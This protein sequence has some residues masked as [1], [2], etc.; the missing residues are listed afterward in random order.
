VSIDLRGRQLQGGKYVLQETIAQGGMATVYTA[1]MRSLDA[2]V[3][4]KILD[5]RFAESEPFRERFRA[6]AH[7]LAALHHPNIIEV[8]DLD[9]DNSVM[10]I[11]MRYVGNGTLKDYLRQIGGPID[12]NL[13]AKL[14]AQIASALQCAHDAGVVHQDIKPAN[15]LL[16]SADWPLLS[17]FGIAGWTVGEIVGT[18][19]YMS[20]EQWTGVPLDGRADQYALALVF[21]QLVAGRLPFQT[22]TISELKTQHLTELP[23]S[24]R[25]FNPGVPGPVDEVL[26]RALSKPREHRFPRIDDFATALVESV[27]RSRGMQLETKQAIVDAT[28]N[29]L[30]AIGVALVTPQLVALANPNL[31]IIGT[32]TLNWPILL[33]LALIESALLL[34]IRW[35]LVGLLARVFSATIDA[36]DRITRM[37][38]RLGTDAEGPLR[39]QRWRNSIVGSAEGIVGIAYVFALY[40]IVGPPLIQTI[41][42]G[43]DYRLEPLIATVVAALVLILAGANVLAI[44]RTSGSVLGT[45]A[46]ALCWAFIAGMPTADRAGWGGISLQWSAKLVIGM[47]VV[48]ALFRVRKDVQNAFRQVV[49]SFFDSSLGR[50]SATATTEHIASRRHELEQSTDALVDVLFFLIAYPILATPL[51]QLL[52]PFIGP[53]FTATF[54]TVVVIGITILLVNYLRSIE[55]VV[56]PTIGLLMCTPMLLGLPLFDEAVAFGPW[57]HW[58]PR[59]LIG[60]AILALLLGIRSRVRAAAQMLLVPV[61]E[62]QISAF[63]A[64]RT[65]QDAEARVRLLR[66]L[67]NTLVDLLY[68]VTAY[69]AVI[70]PLLA[71]LD[72]VSLGWV[73]IVLV[74]LL[75]TAGVWYLYVFQRRVAPASSAAPSP[76]AAADTGIA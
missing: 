30:A 5:P 49:V 26:Q 15:I 58:V 41:A 40:Q 51:R 70:A 67:S 64:P 42:L 60:L 39:V 14:V 61:F 43:V 21:Y 54:I 32:L 71:A 9:E 4:V 45:S 36:L 6:E 33:I 52:P 48:A 75:I 37:Y 34:G 65:E 35:H 63:K 18:P 53:L 59:C 68:V 29:L 57:A 2:T 62:R 3:A 31:P 24:P 73:T 22:D 50:F 27:E 16:G 11:A 12:L 20:P 13:A 8:Y 66:R 76:A 25:E 55:R 47:L 46:L 23:P 56:L 17:D 69:V 72:V 38:V 7:K 28:P 19:Q 10:Y 74:V 44:W 1:H